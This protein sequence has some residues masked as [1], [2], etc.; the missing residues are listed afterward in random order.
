MAATNQGTES[1]RR[2]VGDVARR[3]FELNFGELCG[4]M[5]TL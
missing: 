3:I 4:E 2:K 5:E 1:T